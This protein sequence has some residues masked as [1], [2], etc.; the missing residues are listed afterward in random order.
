MSHP[1][2]SGS[3]SPGAPAPL[4]LQRADPFIRRHD[5][6]FHYFTGSVP[7]YDRIEVRRASTIAGLATA[8]PVTIWEKPAAGPHSA[9]V[10]APEFHRVQG[11]W[12]VYFAAAPTREIKDG[13]FQH[14][15]WAITTGDPDPLAARMAFSICRS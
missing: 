7:A 4:I 14:R 12:V 11:Q 5:D 3:P 2:A 6:G 8:Q 10:W 9:L 13:L 1:S 15:M